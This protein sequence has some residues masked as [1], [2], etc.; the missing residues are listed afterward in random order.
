MN[1]LGNPPPATPGGARILVVDDT[2]PVREIV[3]EVLRA[4]GHE[5]ETAPDAE[6]ALQLGRFVRWD[7]L[8]LDVDLPGM[9][10]PEL[11]GRICR[12]VPDQSLPVV[13]MSGRPQ[14]L[15]RHGLAGLPWVRFLAKP[16]ELAGFLEA[17]RQCLRFDREGAAGRRD[18]N[19]PAAAP[20]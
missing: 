2:A 6:T 9:S 20:G 18:G 14:D 4:A 11:Y 7:L 19:D 5:P 16:F 15:R 1:R 13:F 3:A 8:V 12:A 10:G 17:V